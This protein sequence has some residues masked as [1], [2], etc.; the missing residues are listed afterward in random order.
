MLTI[1]QRTIVYKI[2]KFTIPLRLGSSSYKNLKY[3]K[4]IIS[5]R[6]R[7]SKNFPYI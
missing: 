7:K 1:K 4:K 6:C 2:S 5:L 3:N